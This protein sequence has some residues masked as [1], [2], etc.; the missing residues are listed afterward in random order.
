MTHIDRASSTCNECK[1]RNNKIKKMLSKQCIR[2]V[3]IVLFAI[4][5]TDTMQTMNKK[6]QILAFHFNFCW[7]ILCWIF[8]YFCLSDSQSVSMRKHLKVTINLNS[9]EIANST[10]PRKQSETKH[11]R[12]KAREREREKINH[13]HFHRNRNQYGFDV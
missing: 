6:I 7:S 1:E 12:M 2:I 4:H 13:I 5:F 10:K 9:G 3:S 8:F 11:K